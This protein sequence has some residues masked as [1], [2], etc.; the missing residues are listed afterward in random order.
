MDEH[1][2]CP[3]CGREDVE[4]NEHH[5]IP[6]HKKGKKGEKVDLCTNCHDQIHSLWT[7]NALRD[8]YKTLALLIAAPEM[9]KFAKFI[10]KQKYRS[11]LKRKQK[12][13]RKRRN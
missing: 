8:N 12:N 3:I 4:M 7:N 6:V 2:Q 11:H 13:G 9:Q 5:L 1:N 10:R